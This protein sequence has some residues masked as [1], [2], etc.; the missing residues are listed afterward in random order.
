VTTAQLNLVWSRELL[1]A[2]VKAGLGHVCLSPG[3]RSAPLA[4]AVAERSGLSR[5]V[6]VDERSAAYFAL[7]YARAAGR[8]AALICTSG[9]AAANYLPALVEAHYSR[10]PLV[11]LTADRPRELRD[12]GA[13][14]T[15][16]QVRLYGGYARWF[17]DLGLPEPGADALRY[18]R[19][20]AG[21]AVATATGRPSG[22]VHIN[23]PFREPLTPAWP[24]PVAPEADSDLAPGAAIHMPSAMVSAPDETVSALAERIAAEPRGLIV[25]GQP[26]GPQ[27]PGPY[28]SAVAALARRAGYPVLAEAA[29]GLRYGPHD[30]SL[31]VSHHDALLRCTEW[32]Q[33]H[34]PRLVLRLGASPTWRQPS[35]FLARPA[36]AFHVA[37]DPQLTWDDPH[38]VAALRLAV[39]EEPLCRALEQ[40]L[41]R[42]GVDRAAADAGSA[43]RSWASEWLAADGAAAAELDRLL[44]QTLAGASVAWVYRELRRVLPDGALLC[45][46]NSMAVRDVDTFLPTSATSLRVMANRGAAGI[47]GAVSTALGAALGSGQPTVLLTGDLA[48]AHDLNGLSAASS[49]GVRAVIV[50]LDDGGGGIFDYLPLAAAAPDLLERYF[51]TPSGLDV[52]AACAAYG[53]ACQ[54]A[55]EPAELR[56]ALRMPTPSCIED[57]GR[58]SAGPPV[59]DEAG[60]STG[61]P[62]G[63][64]TRVRPGTEAAVRVVHVRIDRVAN[65]D[66]HRRYWAAVAS[67]LTAGDGS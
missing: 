21:R 51:R 1:H 25:A 60:A 5:T 20:V 46:A 24:P 18:A 32:A 37:I 52:E 49:P 36:D 44:A 14:Q 34:E 53:V 13:W 57:G 26:A 39:D 33:R 10:V 30:R 12:T 31:V 67:A 59:S 28:A 27:P 29:G 23:V 8:P 66:F 22:P 38:R 54:A 3:S 45:A 2:L 9:T 65:T 19:N 15:I 11:V 63:E 56:A 43:D 7:G 4:L 42:R 55:A 17:V 16:D 41:Q 48:F 35:E 62:V 61:P 58:A 64:R 6:H 40:A 47:D 50:V